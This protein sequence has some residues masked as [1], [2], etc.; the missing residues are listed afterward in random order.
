MENDTAHPTSEPELLALGPDEPFRFACGPGIACYNQCC[1]DLN[2]ALTP[3]DVLELRRYL[4]LSWQAIQE[5]HVMLYT[6]PATG[7]PVASLRFA[8]RAGRHCPFVTGQGCSVYPARPTSCRLYPVARAIQ[9]SRTDGRISEHFALLKEPH[10][11][12]FEKG[13]TQTA[14]Q[15]IESQGARA[16]LDASDAMLE[17]IA[18]KNRLRPGPLAPEQRQWAVMAF[19]D[20]ERLKDQAQ[21][22]RLPAMNADALPPLPDRDDDRQWLSWAMAWLRRALFGQQA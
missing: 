4:K 11:H 10:C 7:L 2:Q 21:A 8:S 15:W 9:R 16:G 18:L 20:L 1:Q 19:Y 14:R 6:G 22:G 17:L 3:F 12:G 5:Q 13:L